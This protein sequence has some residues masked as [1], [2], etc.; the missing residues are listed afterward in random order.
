MENKEPIGLISLNT[1]GAGNGG[2]CRSIINFF[3][4]FQKG[5]DKIIFL[6]E[7]HTTEKDEKTWKSEWSNR[8]I[9]YS[10]M[11]TVVVQEL[12]LYSQ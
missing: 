6:Q 1:N 7:T 11:V 12:Q 5:K 10:H 3:N 9:F 8:E 2:K 4:K